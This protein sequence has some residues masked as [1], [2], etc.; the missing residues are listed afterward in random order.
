MAAA[1]VPVLE[2]NCHSDN[3]MHARRRF[4]FV[5]SF[6]MT[7]SAVLSLLGMTSE[8]AYAVGGTV[9][10]TTCASTF[11]GSWDGSTN[12]C[13][14]TNS[15][16][17][18][19]EE[20]LTIPAG[21]T[22]IVANDGTPDQE[23]GIDNAGI[24]TNA[25][26]L[27]IQNSGGNGIAN[28]LGG[29][30]TN[31][32][33]LNIQ[34]NASF[35]KGIVNFGIIENKI[36]GTLMVG[37]SGGTGI[38]SLSAGTITNY[39]TMNIQESG[40]GITGIFN[41]G[42]IDNKASGT[43]T[44]ANTGL[45][46]NNGIFSS[47]SITNSGTLNVLNSGQNSG[48]Q[49][50]GTIDNQASGTLTVANTGTSGGE[51][52][53]NGSFGLIKNM[54]ML[55]VQNSGS[56]RGISNSGGT[57][58]NSGTMNI[59]NSDY[60]GIDNYGIFESTS[61]GMLYIQNS[62]G[63]GIYNGLSSTDGILNHGVITNSGTMTV[64]NSGGTGIGNRGVIHNFGTT[65]NPGTIENF[66]SIVNKCGAIFSDEGIT[67]GNPVNY[68]TCV[69]RTTDFNGDGYADLA[70]GVPNEDIGDIQDAGAVNVIYGSPFGLSATFV[71]DQMFHQNSP[72]IEGEAEAFDGFGFVV[73]TGDFNSDGYSDLAIGAAG[74]DIDTK[75]NAGAVNVMYG[76]P[77]GLSATAVLPE[78]IW[79]KRTPNIEDDIQ[80]NDFFGIALATGD[81]NGDG[82]DD[83]AIGAPSSIYSDE[84]TQG[85]TV[86]TI[87]GSASGLS[88]TTTLPD[89]LYTQKDLGGTGFV[90]EQFGRSLAAGDF[91]SDGYSDLAVGVPGQYDPHEPA[92]ENAGA[93]DIIYGSPTGLS[94]DFISNQHWN[95]EDIG[96]I[97]G[98]SNLF[99][100]SLA[101]GDFNSDGYDDLAAGA[102]NEGVVSI[103]YGSSNG[104]STTSAVP[105]QQWHQ[106]SPGVDGTRE[107]RD[108]LGWA[109]AV[110]DFNNDGYDDLAV[111]VPWEDI[112]SIADAGTVNVIYGSSMG[113]RASVASDET[114][115]ADQLFHQ[116]SP[117]AEGA[118]EEN[119][120]FGFSL[121]AGDFN[122]DG[123]YD[124][125]IGVPGEDLWKN[126]T[127]ANA[128]MINLIYGSP[129]GLS[130]TYIH[131]QVWHQ[132]SQNVK[133]MSEFGDYLAGSSFGYTMLLK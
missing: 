8:K 98:Q 55:T 39:G 76:S 4:A 71:P 26:T 94:T 14:T 25:G 102:H 7:I 27:N 83:L 88:A 79:S 74:E 115:S 121:V 10:G 3:K 16:R 34:N 91:N 127:I 80:E 117:N 112:A 99:G 78:Q 28:P 109:L 32:G 105:P 113:L 19:N 64:A 129:S 92:N 44:L 72:G 104:L 69:P 81:F 106:N 62:D 22:L 41:Q 2:R 43:L 70:I 82:H 36:S 66:G 123:Y 114:G 131:D 57:I 6:I 107:Q 1:A 15:I 68:E 52:I 56:S 95:E 63:T 84:V 17:V 23:V 21:I 37:N 86:T 49:N 60:I 35:S 40:S 96:F 5:I 130:A 9:D 119:D 54:G 47:G 33:T 65:N 48:I 126:G 46:S 111:G 45:G 125:V 11:G 100:F 110:R 38:F 85:G 89:Q 18:E 101:T 12:T 53:S 67:A 122:G 118:A 128:G 116:N 77:S 93:V 108:N 124:L 87:F 61:S 42:T 59:R 31:S 20:T 73:A 58:T 30:I 29:V 103:I 90:E 132:N 24:I 13:T 75:E 50:Q 120:Y 51:G 97:I 133:G